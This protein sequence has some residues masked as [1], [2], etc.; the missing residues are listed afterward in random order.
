MSTDSRGLLAGWRLGALLIGLVVVTAVTV[1]AVVDRAA[2]AASDQVAGR[3]GLRF[4]SPLRGLLPQDD[5]LATLQPLREELRAI[6]AASPLRTSLYLEFLNTGSNININTYERFWPASLTKLPIAIAAMREVDRGAWTRDQVLTLEASDRTTVSSELG[7]APTGTRFTL[8]QVLSALLRGSDNTAYQLL[9]RTLPAGSLEAMVEAVG[10]EELFDTDGRISAREYA[11]LLRTLYTSS[12]L[13][14]PSSQHVLELM[15]ASGFPFFL[16]GAV[17]DAVPF[18]HKW[19][20][21]PDDHTSLDAGIVY[22]P[23]RPYMLVVM[24]Q[25]RGAAGEREAV[26]ALMQQISAA[27]YRF[28]ST[29]T[30]APR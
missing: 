28:F 10:L 11:R 15:N 26:Q 19:G 20:S 27:A 1:L 3:T 30:A 18:P 16:R 17:P 9:L 8:D 14:E 25:G 5:F 7:Q 24:V 13:S 22:V 23:N 21:Y 29:A 4:I 2:P 6:V 12:Y